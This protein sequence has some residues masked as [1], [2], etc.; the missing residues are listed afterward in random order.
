MIAQIAIGAGVVLL[1]LLLIAKLRSDIQ[2]PVVLPPEGQRTDAD[3][4]RLLS[5]RRKVEAIKVYREIHGVSL[6][7]AKEAVERMAREVG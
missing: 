3:V 6:R 4:R 1:V 7:K 2:E 5:L